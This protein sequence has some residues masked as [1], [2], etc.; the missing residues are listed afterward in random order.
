MLSHT[1]YKISKDSAHLFISDLVD[2]ILNKLPA[3]SLHGL[4]SS[5]ALPVY[6]S[7][8]EPAPLRE[9]RDNPSECELPSFIWALHEKGDNF[10]INVCIRESI[11]ASEF[12]ERDEYN[13]SESEIDAYT[14]FTA[15][16]NELETGY[17]L[18]IDY[19]SVHVN[20]DSASN[21]TAIEIPFEFPIKLIYGGLHND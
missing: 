11:D 21:C 6:V 12:D 3:F 15:I 13:N 8:I 14:I 18:T 17:G 5:N 16:C 9:W 20:A 4:P 2:Q 10:K 7:S 1:I 19:S